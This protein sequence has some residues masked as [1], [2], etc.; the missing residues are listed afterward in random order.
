MAAQGC[1]NCSEP[2]SSLHP[3][4]SFSEIRGTDR[5]VTLF[6]LATSALTASGTLI[7]G[8]LMLLGAGA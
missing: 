3:R 4:S 2:M 8:M 5:Q 6:V 7:A 1:Q